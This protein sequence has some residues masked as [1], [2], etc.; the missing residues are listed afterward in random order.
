MEAPGRLVRQNQSRLADHRARDGH[1]LLLPTRK[2][3]WI[4]R[5]LGY[6]LE[7]I[8]NIRDQRLAFRFLDIAI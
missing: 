1:E 8:E 6:D 4:E 3:V 2:L 7:A 5:L